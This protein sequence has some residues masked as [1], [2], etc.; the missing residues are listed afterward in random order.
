M[1]LCLDGNGMG[2]MDAIVVTE[3]LFGGVFIGHG[4][5]GGVGLGGC[6]E[7]AYHSSSTT[8]VGGDV[9]FVFPSGTSKVQLC[10]SINYTMLFF[11]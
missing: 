11:K 3:W 7:F 8:S 2:G 1:N 4:S 6:R 10:H 5:G 9:N